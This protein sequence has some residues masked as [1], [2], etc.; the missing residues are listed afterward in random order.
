MVVQVAGDGGEVLAGNQQRGGQV[1]Q[2][3]FGGGPPLFLPFGHVDQFAAE[4][5]LLLR[6]AGCRRDCGPVF[7][8]RRREQGLARLQRDE[9]LLGRRKLTFLRGV[10]VECLEAQLFERLGVTLQFRRAVGCVDVRLFPALGRPLELQPGI[11]QRLPRGFLHLLAELES[12]PGILQRL[13]D[14]RDRVAALVVVVRLE[15]AKVL[16]Q[17]VPDRA[18]RGQVLGLGLGEVLVTDQGLFVDRHRE[19]LLVGI[20]FFTGEFPQA[21]RVQQGLRVVPVE[22]R[23]RGQ[24]VA[25]LPHVLQPLPDGHQVAE[26]LDDVVRRGKRGGRVEHLVPEEGVDAAAEALAGLDHAE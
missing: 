2:R 17:A 3:A 6:H 11:G 20:E 22:A 26:F 13:L 15:L 10:A 12:H 5:H 24:L 7:N 19:L 21:V 8:A 23:H 18:L 1:P 9:F 16:G 25:L 4:R 14:R